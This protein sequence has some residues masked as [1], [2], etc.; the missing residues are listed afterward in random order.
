MLQMI[1]ARKHAAKKEDRY[2]LF[3]S[4]LDAANDESDGQPTLVDSELIGT[5]RALFNRTYNL[6]R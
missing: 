2:D 5:V 3:S 6:R 4:L 1:H